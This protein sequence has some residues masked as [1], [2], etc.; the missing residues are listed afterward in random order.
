ME[1]RISTSCLDAVLRHAAA[2]P[3]REVCGL[4]FGHEGAVVCATP[5]ANVASDPATRF[6][7]DPAALFAA[8]R[9]E[10]AGGGRVIGYYHSHP[11]GDAMPSAEDARAAAPD[12]KL[13]LIVAGAR[14][15]LWRAGQ[16][17]ACHGRF[18]RLAVVTA[19]AADR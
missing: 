5:A 9:A 12:G 16:D 17:G 1:W 15:T 3:A 10:R 11:S 19:V 6:E 14:W 2:H 7:L 18:T 8:L 13:W 4:L